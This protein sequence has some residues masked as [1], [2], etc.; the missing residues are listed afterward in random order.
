MRNTVPTLIFRIFVILS[1]SCSSVA[2]ALAKRSTA[3]SRI[4]ASRNNLRNNS[5]Y[6]CLFDNY[7]TVRGPYFHALFDQILQDQAGIEQRRIALCTSQVHAER[8]SN[9]LMPQIQQ[10]V[11]LRSDDF[12]TLFILDEYNPLSLQE[13]ITKQQLNPTIFWVVDYDNAF[14]IRYKM[15]TSGLDKIIEQMCGSGNNNNEEEVSSLFIG[16][17][18]GGTI[19][20]GASL[21]TAHALQQDPKE[22][23]EPQFRGLELL[24][25]HRSVAIDTTTNKL[26]LEH[27]KI[28]S[29]SK[30]DEFLTLKDDQIYVWSQPP[31]D[32]VTSFVFLPCQRGGME[33]LEYPPP[34]PPLVETT[35]SVVVGGVQCDGEPSIDPSRTMQEIGDSEWINEAE[36]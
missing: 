9:Q 33:Q 13:T 19:C 34:V 27:P 16:E 25:S 1:P 32:E 35:N 30:N 22:A 18:A 15:R 11:L 29:S 24:G 23:P 10:D 14:R 26:L 31:S 12:C 7:L 6:V 5:R 8:V 36:G 20:G 17:G 4:P 3:N 2:H 21:A 28:K